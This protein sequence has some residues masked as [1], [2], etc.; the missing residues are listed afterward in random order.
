VTLKTLAPQAPAA[1]NLI[2]MLARRATYS[3]DA[4][5]RVRSDAQVTVAQQKTDPGTTAW[6][7]MLRQV[8]G[9]KH[10]YGHLPAGTH[11]GLDAVTAKEVKDFAARAFTPDT[12]ALV[13]AGDLT[14]AAARTLARRAFGDWHGHAPLPAVPGAG[15]SAPERVAIVDTPGAAQTA[16][17]LGEVGLARLDP[18]FERTQVGNRIFGALGLSSRLNINLREKHGYTY[19]VYS[20]LGANR[21]PGLFDISG[22]VE[23]AHTGDAVRE[24]L[25]ELKRIRE[26]DVSATEL[27]QGKQSYL[28][29]IPGLF[30]STS[31]TASTVASMFVLGLPLNYY[32]GLADRVNPLTADQVRRALV[33]HLKPDAL[34]VTAVG[35]KAKIESQLQQLKLG[36][37]PVQLHADGTPVPAPKTQRVA[38]HPRSKPRPASGPTPPKR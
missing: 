25:A 24:I 15:R 10:P 31:D 37:E 21:G 20:Y 32:R 7:V 22:S 34:R 38:D 12:A 8:F 33:R 27:A 35:D 16:L 14:P 11:H 3:A 28:G 26:H 1:V 18:D 29:S 2:S 23:T 4:L 13:L 36:G 30:Q 6:K 19:G 9:P 17:E 5:S